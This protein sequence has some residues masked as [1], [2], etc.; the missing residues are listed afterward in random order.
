VIRVAEPRDAVAVAEIYAPYVMETAISFE[1]EPPSA[2]EMSAR[3]KRTLERYPWLVHEE[4]GRVLGYAYASELRTRAAYRWSV[5]ASVYV[6]ESAQGK[7]IG[8][9]LYLELFRLLVSQGFVTVFGGITLPNDKSVRF[10]EALG[11][12]HVGSFPKV[13]FKFGVW[14][15]VGFWQRPLCDELPATPEEPAWFGREFIDGG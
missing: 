15:D 7:S 3:M 1:S 2:N 4:D 9:G 12:T 11:F 10:H 6:R 13:G 5:E 8:R 14:H